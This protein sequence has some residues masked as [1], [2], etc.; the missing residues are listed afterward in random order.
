MAQFIEGFDRQQTMLLPEHLDDYVDEKS[1]VRAIDA[2]IDLLAL[3]TLGFNAQA[4]ATGRPGVSSWTDA[5]DL[6]LRLSQPSTV[7]AAFGAGMRPQS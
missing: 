2:F 5:A 6:S 1:P 4:A 3:S 7:I